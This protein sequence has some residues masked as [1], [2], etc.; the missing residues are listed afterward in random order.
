MG[1]GKTIQALAVACAYRE[2]WPILVVAPSSLRSNWQNEAKKWVPGLSK[3]NTQVAG[4]CCF[5][6]SLTCESSVVPTSEIFSLLA[7]SCAYCF[8]F[9]ITSPRRE[10][11]CPLSHDF[12]PLHMV[13]ML[14]TFSCNGAVGT[15]Y[16][17]GGGFRLPYMYQGTPHTTGHETSHDERWMPHESQS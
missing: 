17:A 8:L 16:L 10:F 7:C 1:L 4:P 9:E 6:Q 5:L 15:V 14:D 2:D 13:G 3:E 11:T 12:L